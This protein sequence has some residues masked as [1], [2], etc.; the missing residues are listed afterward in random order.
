MAGASKSITCARNLGCV[1]PAPGVTRTSTA[2]YAGSS[3]SRVRHSPPTRPVAPTTRAVLVDT[4]KPGDGVRLH[5][6]PR[7]TGRRRFVRGRGPTSVSRWQERFEAFAPEP[8][9]RLAARGTEPVQK[10]RRPAL[11]VDPQRA[12]APDQRAASATVRDAR[13]DQAAFSSVN[14]G[15]GSAQVA[16]ALPKRQFKCQ[17]A[18]QSRHD[19][20]RRAC[21]RWA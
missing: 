11:S 12:F 1:A 17:L 15:N 20:C 6:R 3:R 7:S 19:G 4:M 8:K 13:P 16:G 9:S 18:W 2:P 10:I 14:V 21:S 5:G